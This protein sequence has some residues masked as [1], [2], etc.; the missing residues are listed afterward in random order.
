MEGCRG[1]LRL[2]SPTVSSFMSLWPHD[3]LGLSPPNSC[4]DPGSFW[5][6]IEEEKYV[7]DL[8]GHVS[9]GNVPRVPSRPVRPAEQNFD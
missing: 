4:D 5:K 3:E 2:A 8:V 9:P 7:I 6:A 1:V